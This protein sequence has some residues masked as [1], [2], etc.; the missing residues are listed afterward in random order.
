[1]MYKDHQLVEMVYGYV[2]QQILKYKF[3]KDQRKMNNSY[4]SQISVLVVKNL[5]REVIVDKSLL[6]VIKVKI[7]II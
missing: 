2:Y 3:L 5:L 7:F 1:M 6:Q 4:P